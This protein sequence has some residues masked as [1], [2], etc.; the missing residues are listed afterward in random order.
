MSKPYYV[1]QLEDYT[2]PS[3]L[4]FPKTYYGTLDQIRQ[5]IYLLASEEWTREYYTSTI[6]AMDSF[7]FG[8][9]AAVHDVAGH[10]E[11]LLT[12]VGELCRSA[13]LCGGAQW[14]YTDQY[15]CALPAKAE[16]VDVEQVLL[17]DGDRY[18]RC[19]K[20][21]F[22]G[23]SNAMPMNGWDLHDGYCEGLPNMGQYFE[24]GAIQMRLFVLEQEYANETTARKDMATEGLLDYSRVSGELFSGY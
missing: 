15:G 12:P 16:L 13:Y 5:L 11:R 2:L 8:N 6:S 4:P 3:Y 10:M 17:Q 23:L 18:L 22:E 9:L 19:G 7:D 20:F 1:I 24:P 14:Y 21:R